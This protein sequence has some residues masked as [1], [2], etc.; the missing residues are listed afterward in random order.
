M[1]KRKIFL[2]T[3]AAL[4]AVCAYGQNGKK[5][6]KAG[7]QFME[8]FK[9][10][11]A[12]SQFTSAIAA[13]PANAA[14]Y[15][16]RGE[17]FEALLKNNEAK[18]DFEKTI[19]FAPKNVDAH[20]RLGAVCNKLGQ[21]EEA[22]VHLNHATGLDKR[23]AGA[24]PEK[25]ITL[26][27]L[28]KYDQALKASDTAIIIKDNP[29]NYY[30]RGI[31]Y[32]KLNNDFSAKKEFEKAIAKDKKIV[33][34]R[35]ALAEL[36][37]K[38]G[39][40]QGAMLQC[41]EIL[42]NDDRNTEAYLMRSKVYKANI[43]FPNAINDISKNIL[44]QPS[45]PD[46]Y[47][48]RGKYYQE[49][50]QHTNAI[51][52]FTKYISLNA[53]NPDAFFDRAKSYEEIMNF[54]KAMEDYNKITQLSEFNQEARKMLKDAQARLYELN[55]ENVPPEITVINPAP[56]NETVEIRG[57]NNVLLISGKIKDKSKIKSLTINDEQ[58]TPVE[59]N[60]EYEFFANINVGGLEKI[61]LLAI[62]DYDNQKPLSYNLVRTEINPPK[63]SIVAPYTSDD[64]LIYLDNNSQT[65]FIQG[66][67]TDESK[68]K[69]IFIDG[70]SGSYAAN[71]INPSFTATVDILNKNKLM[72][73]A[74]DIYG[75]KLST[76]FRLNREGA[77]ISATNPMGKTWVVFI[78]NSD[79][80]TFASLAGPVKDVDRM[81]RALANY[82][83]H[84]FISKKNM[85]KEQMEKF[86]TLELRDQIKS[87]QVK[88]LLIWYAGHGKF[89]NDVGYWIP[90]DA[91]R[92]DEF[93][94][95]NLSTLRAS[96]ESY[97]AYLTHTLVVTD[98]CESGPSFYQAMRSDIKKRS[99]DDWQATQFKSSQ[100]FSSAGYEL[101]V[102]E[103]QFTQTFATT[104]LN[105][106]NA[107]IPIEEVVTKVSTAVGTNNQ[108]KPKFGKI[109]GLKDEDGTFF[110][111]AK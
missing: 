20:V 31:T 109:T 51:N 36:L 5:F 89:I 79:Y 108:Q 98:A 76:E 94:Y 43:D 40:A 64:G 96:M 38:G 84:Q 61:T 82:Q 37:L 58:V 107:C 26:I 110:F 70:V 33:E 8:T 101:A 111:I 99:C 83:V 11:D 67:L 91:K 29:M 12:V 80:S 56:S 90:V 49:F 106:P 78:E 34:P 3:I 50:N 47:L 71:D 2:I 10:E 77:D 63:V 30:W 86:F 54:E 97:L 18:S 75:N 69:S 1:N 93:T 92:D 62:D 27:N 85:T 60:G 81:K 35:L 55:R 87:N 100:V 16:A 32:S 6:F 39:D 15:Y 13:E 102:D 21:Y 72:V 22:L 105:N 104:L 46:F 59:K 4:L 41:N 45:N 53:N 28:E 52:D 48:I 17:A 9:Y 103:S 68:I 88:S 57:D 25:V 42:K 44:I 19:V 66:K 14:F 23:N 7:E 95:F 74:E 65:L 24:Y 73:E